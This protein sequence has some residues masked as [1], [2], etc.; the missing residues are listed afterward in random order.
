MTPDI[1]VKRV[2]DP[3]SPDDGQRILVDRLW[4][5]GLSREKAAL[6]AWDKEIAPSTDL[7]QWFAHDP[8]KWGEF[9]SRYRTEL[10]ANTQAVDELLARAREGCVTL[11][12]GAR[13]TQHNE[14]I[15]LADWLRSHLSRTK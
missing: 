2:Y 15:V 14:A 7:R 4:P 9:I 10:A 11:L 5:R 6:T 1:H 13:D 12:F 3:A 8:A